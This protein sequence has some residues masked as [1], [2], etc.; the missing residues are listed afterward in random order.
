LGVRDV[1]PDGRFGVNIIFENLRKKL[2]LMRPQ[3]TPFVVQMANQW[4]VQPIGLIM[5]LKIDLAIYKISIIVLNMENRVEGYSM[6][7][8]WPWLKHLRAHH[9]WDDTINIITSRE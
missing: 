2:G 5:N 4:R 6:L 8:G 7:L 3:P 1:L 9:N